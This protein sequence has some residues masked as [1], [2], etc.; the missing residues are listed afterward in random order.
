MQLTVSKIVK[1]FYTSQ[2]TLERRFKQ[3][4]N[5]TPL[6]FIRR[7]KIILAAQMLRSGESVLQTGINLG[8]NDP[9]YFVQ[10]F[11]KYYGYTPHEYKHV[12]NQ[13][14]GGD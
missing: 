2:S 1:I 9:S 4:L 14:G 8:Y 3:I 11:K 10:L 6:E 5:I 13:K 7:K 12:G